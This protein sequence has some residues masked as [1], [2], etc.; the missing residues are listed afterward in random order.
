MYILSI[1]AI[2]AFVISMITIYHYLDPKKIENIKSESNEL[3]ADLSALKREADELIR[4][5]KIRR[6]EFD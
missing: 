3:D 1:I 6:K 5:N 2:C 4:I